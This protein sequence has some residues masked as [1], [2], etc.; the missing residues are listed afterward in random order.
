MAKTHHAVN[1]GVAGAAFFAT[2][3]DFQPEEAVIAPASVPWQPGPLPT[4]TE[5]LADAVAA[6]AGQPALMMGAVQRAAETF[7]GLRQ[8]RHHTGDMDGPPAPFSAPRTSLNGPIGTGREV[9][10]VDVS[11]DEVRAVKEATGVTVNDVALALVATAVRQWCHV[12]GETPEDDLVALVPA[13]V[14]RGDGGAVGIVH[15]NSVAPMLVSLATT[16]AGPR[17][18]LAAISRSARAAKAQ[19]A[20]V[21]S[22]VLCEVAEIVAPVVVATAARLASALRLADHLAPSFNLSVSNVPGPPVPV[23]L[24]GGRVEA[25]YP[26]GPVVD[27][28]ALNITALSYAG[29]LA[30]GLVADRDS[31]VGLDDLAAGLVAALA[32]LHAAVAG[33]PHRPALL[34]WAPL[35]T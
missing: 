33:S 20:E 12:R 32:E 23:Y 29:R 7:A 11:F 28:S 16:I 15:G 27:G 4:D 34:G 26:L 25:L 2:V 3:L 18:R 17:E 10:V 6:L 5:V 9:R 13:S 30:F 1:D 14:P 31:S 21:G 24:A 35:R 8:R 19:E 22:A